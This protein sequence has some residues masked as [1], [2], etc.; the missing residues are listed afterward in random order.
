MN[1]AAPGTR[2]QHVAE[3]PGEIL[4]LRSGGRARVRF[5]RRPTLTR[6]VELSA[7]LPCVPSSSPAKPR[8]GRP[9]SKKRHPAEVYD[10]RQ[11]VEAL[12][13]GVV[14][15]THAQAYTV[16]RERELASLRAMLDE[17][18]STGSGQASGLRL[19]WGDYGAGKTHLLEVL[20]Q[21]ALERGFIT[22]R[23]ILD[24]D[25]IPPSHPRRLYRALVTR[26]RYP[27]DAEVGLEP[28]FRKLE[29]SAAHG[30]GRG[31]RSSRFLSPALHVRRVGAPALA[32]LFSELA[33]G[34][35]FEQALRAEM[36]RYLRFLRWD[37]PGLL[38]LPDFRTYGRVYVHLLG[39]IAAWAKDAGYRGL[40]VLLDEVE[41][42]QA[43]DSV[44]ARLAHDVLRHFAAATLPA[45]SLRFDPEDEKS[46]YRGG[47]EVL[48][49]LPL[50]FD[51]KQPLCVTMAL[52]PLPEV[53]A[54]ISAMLD[55]EQASV[56]LSP[57]GR[58]E[59]AELT[60]RVASIYGRAYPGSTSPDTERLLSLVRSAVNG[61]DDPRSVI[62]AVAGFLDLH[63]LARPAGD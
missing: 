1:D 52:T 46:L 55:S 38:A 40:L 13:L 34:A 60:A 36:E 2:V 57:L 51:E 56:R 47:H 27:D 44:H 37:G 15:S 17:A 31:A 63:R 7:L 59:L 45:T 24:A 21:L 50:R 14:P 4:E 58:A 49:K 25:E 12:R 43:L 39:T 32:G 41:G 11:T 22:A 48:R 18:A 6:T 29:G 5:D 53:E 62:R 10:C 26:L 28:L 8:V 33:S 42:V 54:T 3:G 9:R 35:P 20:E 61:Q 19:L 30:S 23:T 16:G